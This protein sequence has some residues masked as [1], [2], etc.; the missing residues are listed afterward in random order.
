MF[1]I[2]LQSRIST[3]KFA[4]VTILTVMKAMVFE[5]QGDIY[6]FSIKAYNTFDIAPID[7]DA[8][9]KVYLFMIYDDHNNGNNHFAFMLIMKDLNLI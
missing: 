4:N 6:I 9:N 5:R 1:K 3:I 8:S 2:N 7:I